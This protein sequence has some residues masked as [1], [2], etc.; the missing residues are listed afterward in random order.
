MTPFFSVVLP[1]YNRASLLPRAILSILNQNYS[2]FDLWIVDD[3]SEDTT[4]SVL[5]KLHHPKKD[6]IHYIK[7]KHSGVSMAR[8]TGVDRSKGEWIAFLDSDDEW[9][10]DKLS[11][12]AEHIQTNPHLP[13]IHGDE[14]WY[15]KGRR[16]NPGKKHHKYSGRIFHHCLSLCLIS[17]S[18]VVIKRTLFD[19]MGGFDP[20]FPV[21]EDY[22]L[23]LRITSLHQVGLVRHP[24]IIK[25]GGHKDQLSQKYKGMDYW[26]I[27]ALHRVLKERTLP[28][29][30]RQAICQEIIRKGNILQRG[31]ERNENT[32]D[33]ESIQKIMKSLQNFQ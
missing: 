6:L 16:I 23:W 15:K 17:P 24:L 29:R 5:E 19:E 22:D 13:L 4:L 10:E 12:Q 2:S 9:L 26:R 11:R 28:S 20:D 18:S 27:L 3:G 33:L 25:H 7:I 30:D 8:N 31:L 32:S 21:C 14:I 1:T